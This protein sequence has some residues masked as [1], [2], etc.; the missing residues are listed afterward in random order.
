MHSGAFEESELPTAELKQVPGK[1]DSRNN[2]VFA[3][4][5]AEALEGRL[6]RLVYVAP[7]NRSPLEVN[8]GVVLG[9]N[10]TQK[11]RSER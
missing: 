7:A 4:T 1:S 8:R 9:A 11:R 10:A 2:A 3:P 6:T 5:S